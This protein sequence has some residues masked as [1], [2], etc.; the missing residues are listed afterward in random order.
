MGLTTESENEVPTAP[1]LNIQWGHAAAPTPGEVRGSAANSTSPS[2][3]IYFGIPKVNLPTVDLSIAYPSSEVDP[4]DA[5]LVL[6]R[7]K[8]FKYELKQSVQVVWTRGRHKDVR[9][10]AGRGRKLQSCH[11]P[12]SPLCR[13]I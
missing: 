12:G 10:P 6:Q 4:A 8:T 1:L 11:N 5:H 7:V 9:I 3:P 13:E 2:G